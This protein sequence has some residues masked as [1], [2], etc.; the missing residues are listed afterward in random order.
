MDFACDRYVP[1]P[2]N[3]FHRGIDVDAPP[4]IVFRWLCQLRAAPYSYDWIDNLGRQSPRQLTPGME[5][6]D[7]GQ[8]FVTI[9]YL[10]E[11]ETNEQ[12]T[13]H[14]AEG[15]WKALFGDVACTYVLV[16]SDADG[17]RIVVRVVAQMRRGKLA[18]F[19]RKTFPWG[20]LLMLRRQLLNLKEL[21]EKQARGH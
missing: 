11:Y 17:T 5:H 16:P 10:A 21:A 15:K 9:F 8:K 6:L 19:R 18:A 1:T 12:L 14:I 3:V 20:E 4:E 13:L 2:H 7:V